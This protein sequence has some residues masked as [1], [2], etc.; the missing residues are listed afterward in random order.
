[1]T[2]A[3]T[4]V[5]VVDFGQFIA[6]P[7]AAQVLADLGADVIKIEGPDGE[8][9][10]AVGIYGNAMLRAY[11]RNK[12]CIAVDLKNPAGLRIARE[13]V[14][15]ADIVIQ[16]LRPGA[17]ERLGLG[18]QQ[19]RSER[20]ELVYGTVSG[21]GSRGPSALRTGF[22]IA[23]Q[24]ESGI[25]WVTGEPD[26]EPQRVGFPVVDAAAGHVLAEAVLGAYI[27]RLRFGVGD[28]IE[29]SLLDVAI[30]L[31][32]ANWAE[33]FLTG[34]E[35]VRSGNGQP[36]V[37]PAADVVPT[38]D[39]LIVLSAYHPTHF[40]TLCRIIGRE[41]LL[42]DPRFT[43]NAGRVAHRDALLTDIRPAFRNSTSDE[44]VEMLTRNGLVCGRIASYP[45]V[46]ANPDVSASGIFCDVKDFD[47]VHSR[48]L[49]PAFRAASD[50]VGVSD[51]VADVG[52]HTAEVL[53]DLGY[54]DADVADLAASGAV[55]LASPLEH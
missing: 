17:M 31:Q 52:G 51:G 49:G 5:R 40:A 27:R 29:V 26:G 46:V 41:D 33:Y 15:T 50:L 11:N 55:S 14:D 24:A 42:T 3:L 21:F 19:L 12:R 35:P 38:S 25:M 6:A 43:D 37:A 1:M 53:R 9:A 36:A 23:A 16:N 4:G 22:D 32:G 44:A 10:R 34:R 28:D 2:A 39:G 13:L 18:S 54:D 8:G 45:D 20:P 47:G 30:H 48:G 7:A